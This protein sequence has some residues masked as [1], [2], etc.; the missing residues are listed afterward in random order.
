[1]THSQSTIWKPMS[2]KGEGYNF[3]C[4]LTVLTCFFLSQTVVHDVYKITRAKDA[5]FFLISGGLHKVF[6]TIDTTFRRNSCLLNK[7]VPSCGPSIAHL[8]SW[9]LYEITNSPTT[10]PMQGSLVLGVTKTSS[11]YSRKNVC[12]IVRSIIHDLP[13]TTYQ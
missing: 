7:R 5:D 8:L 13:Y 1:M 11:S 4:Q 12:R 2:S 9:N 3:T 6:N 10:P